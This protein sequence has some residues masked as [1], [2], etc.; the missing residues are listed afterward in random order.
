MIIK[1]IELKNFRNYE[2]LDLSFDDG[3]NILYGD[4]AQGKTNI[5]EAAYLSGTTKSHK[6]SRDREMIRFEQQE[7][8]IRTVVQKNEKQYQIDM[9]LRKNGSK[10][11]AI[12]KIP[13]KKA[14]ELFGILNIVFFSPE[15]L[16]IIKNG[17]SER[18]RFIDLE[19][20]QLDKL[21]LS[22]LSRY[23]KVLNQR[24]KLLKDIYY[25]GD[26]IDTLPMWDM[27]LVEYGRRIIAK[28]KQFVEELN[29]IIH[30]I[31]TNITGG[32]ESLLLKYEP[33][34]DDIFFEDELLR[35]KK[36]DLKLCQTT[37]GPHRDD[38]LFSIGGVDIRK[39]GSQGQQRTCAL[40]L[41][42]SEIELVKKIIHN[43][44]V[45][46]LDDVLSELDSSRQNYL[47]GSITDTQ[48]II[49]C[50]G[51]DEFVKNR[52][53]INKIFQVIEGKVFEK[54][55]LEDI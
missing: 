55:A 43:T 23:N 51:L 14:S 30:D 7:A 34:I 47:L 13:I 31:H 49:T 26:L 5:L 29:A 18:R 19:L 37:V 28:R 25:R 46:M 17:P 44:P 42:L 38:M 21:Y 40:S 41:K 10:G 53:R 27:Q 33:N 54:K 36:K 32:K 9:H 52:F 50:T 3:T 2:E 45:L 4:N 22:D 15:D 6:G 39:F 1:S 20:C 16:N 48:T 35:A 24:N 11:V 8:H 12:N